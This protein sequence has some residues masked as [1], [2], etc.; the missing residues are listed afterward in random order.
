MQVFLVR[1]DQFCGYLGPLSQEKDGKQA[2]G[3]DIQIVMDGHVG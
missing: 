3:G 1:I 2:G